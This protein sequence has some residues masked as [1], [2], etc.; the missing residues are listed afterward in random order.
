MIALFENILS[1]VVQQ[2][3]IRLNMLSDMLTEVDRQQRIKQVQNIEEIRRQKFEGAKRKS[4]ARSHVQ[5]KNK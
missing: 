3:D 2:P 5:N 4:I 1:A